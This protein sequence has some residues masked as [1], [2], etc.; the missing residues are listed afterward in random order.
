MTTS[1]WLDLASILGLGMVPV[2]VM[3][4]IFGRE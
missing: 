3:A 4:W 1:N 2:A